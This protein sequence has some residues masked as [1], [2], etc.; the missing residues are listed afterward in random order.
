VLGKV[1]RVLPGMQ[2]AF[3]DV[4]MERAAFLHVEDLIRPDDF[5]AY[6]A[7]DLDEDLEKATDEDADDEVLAEGA[8]VAV[9]SNLGESAPLS[10][11]DLED[12]EDLDEDEDDDE[13]DEDDD[14]D[15]ED[16]DEDDYDDS[17]EE[18]DDYEDEDDDEASE[19]QVEEGGDTGLAA[20]DPVVTEP[21]APE[22]TGEQLRAVA[23]T[24]RRRSS[25]QSPPGP[26]AEEPAE[27]EDEEEEVTGAGRRRR[28]RRRKGQ[29]AA[30]RNSRNGARGNGRSSGKEARTDLRRKSAHRV[31]R[32]VP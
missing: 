18:E 28:R 9:P 30:R 20:A 21:S 13:G 3:I 19:D 17:D 27:E 7:G 11:E 2:A 16:S 29:D 24:R 26:E 15:D 23:P 25:V 12:D 4:G 6:L 31:S 32:S 14:Y 1:T 5:E 8:T 22:S 10:D